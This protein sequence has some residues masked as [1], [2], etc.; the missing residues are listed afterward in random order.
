M[1]SDSLI[2]TLFGFTLLAVIVYGVWQLWRTREAQRTHE[3]SAM[4]STA[5]RDD[6]P[7]DPPAP[8]SP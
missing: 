5:Q 4:A 3:H 6:A 8:R 7:R 1:T 2:P